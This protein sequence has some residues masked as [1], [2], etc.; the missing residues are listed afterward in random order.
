M[1]IFHR[2]VSFPKG[3]VQLTQLGGS[4]W[5]AEL[6]VCKPSPRRE[7]RIF[8]DVGCGRCDRRGRRK[9]GTYM[10]WEICIN[11]WFCCNSVWRVLVPF[12]VPS[13]NYSRSNCPLEQ[14]VP[15]QKITQPMP[16][17]LSF[18]FGPRAR[19]PK[20]PKVSLLW[21]ART[22]WTSLN[23]CGR[24]LTKK[25]SC[26]LCTLKRFQYPAP[27]SFH[28]TWMI[29][30]SECQRCRSF[31]SIH[32]WLLWSKVLTDQLL[33]S[34]RSSPS[35]SEPLRFCCSCQV[36]PDDWTVR[37]DALWSS[38]CFLEVYFVIEYPG[39]L[40]SYYPLVMTN[41]AMENC[42]FTD[43]LPIKNGDFPW[44]C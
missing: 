18:S 33:H 9:L 21:R 42:P 37:N 40:I 22:Q 15:Q 32:G 4:C 38:D 28:Q 29:G 23:F 34:S 14:Q 24:L 16:K 25:N 2:Y 12:C 41:I 1:V 26:D 36:P 10:T 20:Y 30:R 44:L 19:A 8:E 27:Y 6:R 5:R 35:G 13:H 39:I 31:L 43:G 11:L 17:L 3:I 7:L